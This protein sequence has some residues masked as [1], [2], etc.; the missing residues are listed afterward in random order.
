MTLE[1]EG[2]L[3]KAIENIAAAEV[4]LER[5]FNNA[6][7][8]RCYYAMFHVAIAALIK[9]G[10][11]PRGEQWGH[12]YVQA[13][14]VTHLIKRRKVLPGALSSDLPDVMGRRKAADYT[15]EMIGEKVAK[16]T[17]RKARDFVDEVKEAIK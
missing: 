17:F 4:C 2:W 5:G 6:S 15:T 13:G 8:N 12:D 1:I 14:L 10:I 9:F 11:K 16:R 7:V 3:A